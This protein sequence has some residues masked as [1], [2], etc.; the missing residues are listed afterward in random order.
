MV[1]AGESLGS[2]YSNTCGPDCRAVPLSTWMLAFA[3]V[4]ML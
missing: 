4:G 1:A 3:G 2:V